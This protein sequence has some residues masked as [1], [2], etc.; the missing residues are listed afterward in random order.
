MVRREE[1]ERFR[2]IVARRFGLAHDDGKLDF[3]ADVLVRR[4]AA[5]RATPSGYC[6]GLETIAVE[7]MEVRELT[8]RLTV[9]ET[10]FF[11]NV[12]QFRALIDVMLPG[13][14]AARDG[15]RRLSLLSLGCASGEEIYSAAACLRTALP[16]VDA[17]SIDL[18]GVD[19]NPAMIDRARLARYSAWSMRATPHE[20]VRQWFHI[21]GRDY[22]V[23]PAIVRMARFE[24]R[25]I[26]DDDPGFWRAGLHDIVLFRNV[27]MYFTPEAASATIARIA[28]SI[29]PGGYLLL[30]HAETLRGLS[31]EFHL[32][33]THDTFYY[34]KRGAPEIAHRTTAAA[35]ES[36]DPM[37]DAVSWIDAIHRASER[38]ASL[39]SGRATPPPARPAPVPLDLRAALIAVENERFAEAI[40]VLDALPPDADR[41]PDALLIRA[42]V[43]VNRGDR[44]HAEATCRRLLPVDELSAGAHYVMALCREHAGDLDAALAHDRTSI[45][46]DAGFA[47]PHLHLG[48]IA[49]RTGDV[50][51]ARRELALAGMLLGRED[52]SRVLLF[53][54]G[55]SRDAL[56]R[57]CRVELSAAEVAR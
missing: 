35:A 26:A 11:R 22:V 6:D 3:L 10:F 43:L 51:T 18:V 8:A 20:I 7:S 12:E 25:N 41:D 32:C 2:S 16:D 36:P 5:A 45:Y 23:D 47:M 34:R 57:L 31:D 27:M 54:G 24:H 49:R 40:A 55:F 13:R 15:D 1:V 39:D 50:E 30:G 42:V 4:A 9:G 37:D 44:D 29:A 52:A 56:I 28:R 53:G 33:H 19:V 14:L 38:I 17:W 46:L 48:L 21:D